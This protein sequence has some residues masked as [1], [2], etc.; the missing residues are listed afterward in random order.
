[1]RGRRMRFATSALRTDFANAHNDFCCSDFFVHQKKIANTT[2]AKQAKAE[3]ERQEPNRRTR[4]AIKATI[5]FVTVA[6]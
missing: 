1:M 6:A 2:K 5:V 3:S 4:C